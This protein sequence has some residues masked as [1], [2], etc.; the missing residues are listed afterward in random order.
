LLVVPIDESVIP[1]WNTNHYA[2]HQAAWHIR[3]ELN[4]EI[5]GDTHA[6][7][8]SD[9]ASN[10]YARFVDGDTDQTSRFNRY[11]GR[12]NGNEAAP[13]QEIVPYSSHQKR[14]RQ[15]FADYVL[16][17][18]HTVLGSLSKVEH[19]EAGQRSDG[20]SPD[21]LDVNQY[22]LAFATAMLLKV[23]LPPKISSI[24]IQGLPLFDRYSSAAISRYCLEAL[25]AR[26]G[27]ISVSRLSI[28]IRSRGNHPPIHPVLATQSRRDAYWSNV[29]P[30]FKTLTSLRLVGAERKADNRF[31]K[32]ELLASNY[33][34]QAELWDFLDLLLDGLK[35]PELKILHLV[36]WSATPDAIAEKLAKSFLKLTLLELGRIDLISED[37]GEDYDASSVALETFRGHYKKIEIRI[38]GLRQ[39]GPSR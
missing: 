33:A 38:E 27:N 1:S 3:A 8:V 21:E 11:F 32:R 4:P 23:P 20:D 14:H 16:I 7:C 10:V 6:P 5:V 29:L 35:L 37:K 19:L 25:A 12:A 26:A 17:I 39:T 22:G 36:G 9:D 28:D 34:Y 30:T 31:K 18:L 2:F 13:V 24:R 15:V